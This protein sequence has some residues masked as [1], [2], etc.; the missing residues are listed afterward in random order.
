MET[1]IQDGEMVFDEKNS[2]HTE[3]ELEFWDLPAQPLVSFEF[4]ET[5]EE[6]NKNPFVGLRRP[7]Q[8]EY[9]YEVCKLFF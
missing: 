9:T 7:C 2:Y 4:K 6:I 5:N 1:T 3:K 8:K